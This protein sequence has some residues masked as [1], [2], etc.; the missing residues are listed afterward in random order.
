MNYSRAF[1]YVFEDKNWLS[2]ILI[3][4]LISLIPIIGQFYL[5]GWMVEIV[6]RTKAGRTDILP[7]THFTYFLTL[8]LKVFVVCLIYSIPVIILSCILGL[9]NTSVESSDSNMIAIIFTGMGCLGSILTFVVN[10]A[11]SLLGTYG[12]IRL[13]ETDQIK[14][15]L[16]FNDAFNTIKDNIGTFIIVE[17]LALVAGLIQGAGFIICFVGAILTVP[18]GVA[19]TGNLVGQLWDNLKVNPTGSKPRRTTVNE[20]ANDIIEEAPFT[21]VEEIEK[22]VSDVPEEPKNEEIVIDAAEPII[23]ETEQV[24]SDQ[25]QTE[26]VPESETPV[27]E[28]PTA[29]A[30]PQ[31][32]EKPD[33][34]IPSFE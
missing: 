21:K 18:Y 14:A 29:E 6:R 19:V 23:E 11:V 31:E 33:T 20:P 2:K 13:A 5:C 7:T 12:I 3:A 17:L 25:V 26:A 30:E 34:D 16:D 22:Q 9:M 10:V 8:G 28:A 1:S 32:E 15:C 27:D 4:G 24:I